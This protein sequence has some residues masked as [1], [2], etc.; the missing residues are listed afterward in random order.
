MHWEQ[1]QEAFETLQKLCSNSPILA[2][3]NFKAPFVLH[4]DASGEGLGVVLYQV[5]EVKKKVI[6]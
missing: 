6:A 4:T 1:E 5:Q 2:D 3:T